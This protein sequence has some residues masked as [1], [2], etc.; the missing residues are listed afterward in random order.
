MNQYF[1]LVVQPTVSTSSAPLALALGNDTISLTGFSSPTYPLQLATQSLAND[2][3]Q[4]WFFKASSD[5]LQIFS[6]AYPT[7]A[8]GFNINDLYQNLANVPYAV[9]TTPVTGSSFFFYWNLALPSGCPPDSVVLQTPGVAISSFPCVLNVFDN[10]FQAGQAVSACINSWMGSG[11]YFAIEY[12]P[13]FVIIQ[14]QQSTSSDNWVLGYEAGQL[15][16]GNNVTIQ[17]YQ[18]GSLSQVWRCWP[19]G[20][21]RPVSDPSLAISVNALSNSTPLTFET[22]GSS[23]NYQQWVFT[24]LSQIACASSAEVVLNIVGNSPSVNQGIEAWN[25][26]GSPSSGQLFNMIPYL[27][28]PSG[29]YFTVVSGY[30][31]ASPLMLNAMTLAAQPGPSDPTTPVPAQQLWKLT[32]DG[33]LVSALNP[34]IGL[35]GVV[36]EQA[37]SKNYTLAIQSLQAGSKMQKWAWL[38]G[39][40]Q[41][42]TSGTQAAQ[43]VLVNQGL[44]TSDGGQCLAIQNESSSSAEV[45]LQAFTYQDPPTAQQQLWSMPAGGPCFATSTVIRSRYP[46]AIDNKSTEME[47]VLSVTAAYSKVLEN[48][49]SGPYNLSESVVVGFKQSDGSSVWTMTVDGYIVNSINP[50]LV[51]SLA[52]DSKSTLQNP[53]YD[54]NVVISLKSKIPYPAQFWTATAEGIIYSRQ[55]G[56]VLTVDGTF[57]PATGTPV[58]VIVTPLN[59]PPSPSQIWDYGTGKGLQSVLVQPLQPFPYPKDNRQTYDY[60]DKQLGLKDVTLRDQYLNLAAPLASYQTALS[61]MPSN[62]SSDWSTVVEQLNSELTAAIAVQAL[63]QQVTNLHVNL[64]LQQTQTLQELATLMAIPNN[65]TVP[66]KKKKTWIWDMIE[67]SV[68][69]ALN[70]AG[71]FMGDPGEGSQIKAGLKLG[72]KLIGG[73]A[74][75]LQTGFTTGQ[76]AMQSNAAS[77]QSAKAQQ[78]LQNIEKYEMTIVELQQSLRSAFQSSGTAIGKIEETILS[79]WGKLR[80]VYEMI[81]TPLGT[82]SLYWSGNFG[83]ME[84]NKLLKSYTIQLLQ[85]LL[86]IQPKTY[87]ITGQ[88]L[89]GAINQPLNLGL[90]ADGKTFICLTRD[91][92][93]SEYVANGNAEVLSIIWENI[94]RPYD[95]FNGLNGWSLPVN[96]VYNSS[97]N[98]AFIVITIFNQT[99]QPMTLYAWT[100]YSGYIL[101]YGGYNYYRPVQ[102]F[103]S[104]TFAMIGPGENAPS[105]NLMPY[106]YLDNPGSNS[107]SGGLYQFTVNVS[108]DSKSWVWQVTQ[109]STNDPTPNPP[110]YEHNGTF[111]YNE[112]VAIYNLTITQAI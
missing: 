56:M 78:A 85:T 110:G 86:P 16:A 91:G 25:T 6:A 17:T 48:N 27:P 100:A 51:L 43:G 84:V 97:G 46:V 64:G 71:A 11:G 33:N 18:D 79:D 20:T 76:A 32:L 108:G 105:F 8:I 22:L 58:P 101:G 74:N 55:N 94:G 104:Q 103:G 82:S 61:V 102:P 98:S 5:G 42:S 52:V 81:C 49:E 80:A 29:Q 96:Y 70:F 65:Q 99:P 66:H 88:S 112:Q 38:S 2:L 72:S 21:I 45:C 19:D 50:D 7:L 23:G 39:S 54:T 9:A 63:F 4:L 12:V 109:D 73:A 107:P 24:A 30:E 36:E 59:S 60:V 34:S 44:L 35:A 57:D 90:Q 14:S 1:R 93:Q 40:T 10:V 87:T 31:A 92:R 37:G 53:I 89:H 28:E 83:P 15:E 41:S 47:L 77:S 69:T 3:N 67:G 75:L 62:N 106:S 13:E 26:S 68:Y 111:P 95:F